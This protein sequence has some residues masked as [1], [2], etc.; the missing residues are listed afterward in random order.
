MGGH[1]NHLYNICLNGELIAKTISARTINSLSSFERAIS[2]SYNG[3]EKLAF[4]NTVCA[5]RNASDTTDAKREAFYLKLLALCSE[6]N[7]SDVKKGIRKLPSFAN[8]LLKTES[9]LAP[10]ED[11]GS[12]SSSI[13]KDDDDGDDVDD[14]EWAYSDEVDLQECMSSIHQVAIS[15]SETRR[16]VLYAALGNTLRLFKDGGKEDKCETASSGSLSKKSRYTG[17]SGKAN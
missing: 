11:D 8:L 17:S 14:N 2:K 10:P 9:F 15:M 7:T 5:L 4:W 12:S 16:Q 3:V 1:P 13:G 6:M